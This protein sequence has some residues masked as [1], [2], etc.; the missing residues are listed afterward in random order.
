MGRPADKRRERVYRNSGVLYSETSR[1]A[2]N[3]LLCRRVSERFSRRSAAR[4]GRSELL[5]AG[6]DGDDSLNPQNAVD[7]NNPA[8]DGCTSGLW[9]LNEV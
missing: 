1:R 2:R 9:D 4:P 8:G 5:E 3:E 7:V 6:G